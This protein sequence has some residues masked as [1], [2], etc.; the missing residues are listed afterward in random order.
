MND[1]AP[2]LARVPEDVRNMHTKL[3][4]ESDDLG[5]GKFK[6]NLQEVRVG[7]M[8]SWYLVGGAD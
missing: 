4:L 5:K 3:P 2:Y 6:S 7:K 8:D 1:M